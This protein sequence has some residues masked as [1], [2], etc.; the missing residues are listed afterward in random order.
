[1]SKTAI[2]FSKEEIFIIRDSCI[3]YIKELDE[4]VVRNQVDDETYDNNVQ[5]A[6]F[7]ISKLDEL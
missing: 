3:A 4:M 7:I 2:K 1:M 6:Q 5:I